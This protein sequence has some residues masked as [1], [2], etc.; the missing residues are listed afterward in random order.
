VSK[1]R[2]EYRFRRVTDNL[3]SQEMGL[4]NRVGKLEG[5][6]DP[7]PIEREVNKLAAAGWE[8]MQMIPQTNVGSLLL[9]FRRP[10]ESAEAK[11]GM[12]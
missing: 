12:F 5:T 3:A 2:W 8:L 6:G 10:V 7:G 1:Q 9:V 4:G 11:G